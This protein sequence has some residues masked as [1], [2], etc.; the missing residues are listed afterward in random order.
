M[1]DIWLV[2]RIM[3]AVAV[4]A[5]L[6]GCAGGTSSLVEPSTSLTMTGA[7]S[8]P[9]VTVTP[10]GGAAAA[11]LPIA[12]A[13][14]AGS[15]SAPPSAPSLTAAAPAVLR[16]GSSGP[17]VRALQRQLL[18]LGYWLSGVDG[19]YGLTTEQAVLALQKAAGITRD[20]VYGP[21]TARALT[22]G[23]R[24]RAHSRS[25]RVLEI[26]RGRQL[27]LIVT[28]GRVD[29]VLNTST[30]RPGWTTPLGRYRIFRTVNGL[31]RGPLGDLWRPRYFNRGIAIHG[32]PFIPGY[33]AS[34][35]CARVSNAAIDWMWAT[36]QTP[37]GTAVWVYA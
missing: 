2:F 36:G 1:H 34:H 4:L 28:D 10:T 23:V 17:R 20:G 18:G 8:G 37:I 13:T 19:T 22:A 26:D 25:G 16:P 5:I 32:S 14:P 3:V 12:T 29:A 11:P 6:A 27:A 21:L 31:D 35:G 9:T 7:P 15:P 30:G 33:P 24:P